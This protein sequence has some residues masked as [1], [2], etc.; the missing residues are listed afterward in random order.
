MQNDGDMVGCVCVL[1][2]APTG[3]RAHGPFGGPSRFRGT[4]FAVRIDGFAVGCTARSVPGAG[5]L[6]L[7]YGLV[8]A[9]EGNLREPK[10]YYHLW[11]QKS[12]QEHTTYR[13]PAGT[14][15]IQFIHDV[16]AVECL[17]YMSSLVAWPYRT[18]QLHLYYCTWTS[19]LTAAPSSQ[20]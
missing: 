13:D 4:I 10:T 6:Y 3:Q 11:T 17:T 9:V 1:P 12:I 15:E 7:S 16:R 19:G 14:P 8:V 18:H 5:V 2:S 20:A